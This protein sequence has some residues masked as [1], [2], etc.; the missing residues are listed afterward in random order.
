MRKPSSVP[1]PRPQGQLADLAKQ[2]CAEH[3][4][5]VTAT[6]KGLG[7][8]KAAGALLLEAQQHVNHGE[9]GAWLKRH[10]EMSE[11]VAQM[12]MRVAG[13]WAEIEAKAKPVSDLTLKS[14][15]RSIAAPAK[16]RPGAAPAPARPVAPL[17]NGF[18]KKRPT[19]HDIMAVWFDA[20]N[21]TRAA[22]MAD[23]GL[24]YRREAGHEAAEQPGKQVKPPQPKKAPRAL[25]AGALAIPADPSIPPFLKVV[26][27]PLPEVPDARAQ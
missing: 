17:T 15:L 11:R 14:A 10:C 5:V 3:Q 27:A 12:Y 21:E 1:T 24:T 19:K 16:A 25:A 8:A 7:H 22:F 4:Q 2:I 20:D 23:A 26:A 18:G 9:W 6:A 13:R